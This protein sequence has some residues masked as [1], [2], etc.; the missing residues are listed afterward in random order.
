M[1]STT[2]HRTVV[3]LL[4]WY[5]NGTLQESERRSVERHLRECLP[6]RAA[7]RDERRLAT[8]LQRDASDDLSV[9]RNFERLIG[10]IQTPQS[11]PRATRAFGTLLGR[12]PSRVVAAAAVLVVVLGGAVMWLSARRDDAVYSTATTTA[13]DASRRIDIIFAAGV[14]GAEI[15]DVLE[16]IHGT[17]VGGPTEIGRYTVRLSDPG[18]SDAEVQA[19]VA[20]LS[21]DSRIRFAGRSFIEVPNK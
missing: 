16:S 6:C 8:A 7:L 20:G 1:T 17:I 18:L 15:R 13:T 19:V 14:N 4:P 10:R 9:E 5:V 2:E 21:K 3:E 11:S 12:V